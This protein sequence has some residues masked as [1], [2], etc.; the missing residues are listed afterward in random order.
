MAMKPSMGLFSSYSTADDTMR[1]P[2]CS[3]QD[4]LVAILSRMNKQWN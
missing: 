1:R 2:T 3:K 4:A